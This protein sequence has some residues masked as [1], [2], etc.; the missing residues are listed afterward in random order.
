MSEKSEMQDKA[1]EILDK[2]G[3][4]YIHL[5]NRMF[6]K[7]RTPNKLK[8]LPDVMFMFRGTFYMREFKI[9]GSHSDREALQREKMA[10][11]AREGANT[12]VIYTQADLLEDFKN[13]GLKYAD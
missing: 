9:K 4:E 5:N 8:S 11:W 10:L 7:Y 13:I 1:F 3:L 2:N 6:G 12:A